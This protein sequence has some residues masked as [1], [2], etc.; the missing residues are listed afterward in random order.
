MPY[1]DIFDLETFLP[2]NEIPLSVMVYHVI[3]WLVLLIPYL[4]LLL[5]NKKGETPILLVLAFRGISIS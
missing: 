1:L 5:P 3:R 2:K 4:A